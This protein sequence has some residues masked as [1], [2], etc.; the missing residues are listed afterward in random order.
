[1]IKTIDAALFSRM[2]VSGANNLSNNRET[3]DSLNV[4]PVPDGDTGTNMSLTFINAA[5]AVEGGDFSAVSDVASAVAKA[6]L[7]GARGNSGVILSQI[8]RGISKCVQGSSEADASLLAAAFDSARETA[9]RAVM[10]PT[11]GTI[12]TVVR[13]VAQAA[14]EFDGDD[15]T[16]LFRTI[17]EKGNEAL[18]RTTEMLPQLAQAGVVD[19]GGQGLMFILEGFLSELCGNF[20]ILKTGAAQ[21]SGEKPAQQAIRTEDIR[22]AY[23]TEFI[24]N[25][26]DASVSAAKLKSAIRPRGDCMLVIDEDDIVKVHIHTNHPGFVLEQ[27]VKLGELVNIKIENMRQQHTSIL[28]GAKKAEEAKPEKAETQPHKESA[29]VSVASG[30]GIEKTFREL[31]ADEIIRGGQTMNPSTEDIVNA[32]KKVNADNVIILPNNKNIIL[33]AQQAQYLCDCRI[34]VIESK[35]IPQGISAM[36]AY[37]KTASFDNNAARMAKALSKV[38]SGSVTHA[39]KDTNIDGKEIVSGNIIG[40]SDGHILSV[41]ENREDAAFEL[42]SAIA[43]EDSEIITLYRGDGVSEDDI[44]ALAA[45]VE[46]AFPDADVITAD[47]GQPVYFYIISVE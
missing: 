12:L 19:A 23:C 10:K 25:K 33:A 20:V 32:I 14:A 8:F 40:V 1:M 27:A 17:A 44:S 41:S 16:E 35:S 5:R 3:V 6:T 37:S 13:M 11:E 24:V 45:R 39:V 21:S 29:I 7:R 18:S 43:D 22:F 4:F 47:G 42:I 2:I 31:G 26:S 38:K 9:Y 46:D 15:C 30:E 34:I 36:M 28:D